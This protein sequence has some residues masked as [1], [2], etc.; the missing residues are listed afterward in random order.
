MKSRVVFIKVHSEFGHEE[1]SRVIDMI[2]PV[3]RERA[4]S[5]V[6]GRE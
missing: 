4:Y 6:R 5:G 1:N 2:K 3:N